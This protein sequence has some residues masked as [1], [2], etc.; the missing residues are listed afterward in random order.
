MNSRACLSRIG[1]LA[2]LVCG[3]SCGVE[4]TATVS[5]EASPIPESP[6]AEGRVRDLRERFLLATESPPF[7]LSPSPQPTE[8]GSRPVL[9]VSVAS[10][11]EQLDGSAH[12]VIP[13]QARQGVVRTA[14]VALPLHANDPV[15]LEDD[16]SHVVVTFALR[17][18]SDVAFATAGGLALYPGAL[19]GADVVHRVHAEGTEDYLVF[20]QRPAHEEIDY[21]VDVS[22]VAGL[23]L[24]SNTLEFLDEGGAPRLRVAPPYVVDTVGGRTEGVVAV[25][26]CAFDAS[27]RAPSGRAVTLPG[28]SRCE[29]RVGWSDATY[30]AMVDPS[31]TATGSMVT[32]RVGHTA[33]LL[34]SGEVLMAGGANDSGV[35]SS[36]ELYDPTAGTFTATG[37]MTVARESF[38]ATLLASGEVLMAAG[39]T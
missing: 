24:V 32:A 22:R 4:P 33:T 9:G 13:A 34:A 3:W 8:E 12:A 36:A 25:E 31:W 5:R 2:T 29:V 11:F 7:A 26:G 6:A 15:R 18:A 16:A 10:G 21:E 39:F 14:S 27:P 35:L 20:E 28:A 30:P 37:P 19:A 38:T 23:R 17:G 1:L